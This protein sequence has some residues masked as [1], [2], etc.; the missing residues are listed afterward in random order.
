MSQWSVMSLFSYE[1]LCTSRNSNQ[2]EVHCFTEAFHG[3]TKHHIVEVFC[4][5]PV[6][7]TIS[8]LVSLR[9]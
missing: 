8:P 5:T 4:S 2:F 1:F 6:E 9:C 3:L 7:M